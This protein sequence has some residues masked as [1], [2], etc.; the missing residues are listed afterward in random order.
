[1]SEGPL[2][3]KEIEGRRGY[4]RCGYR[5][6]RILDCLPGIALE[7]VVRVA[8]PIERAA[9]T[10]W[11]EA[12]RAYLRRAVLFPERLGANLDLSLHELDRIDMELNDKD[13]PL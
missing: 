4:S 8:R 10:A 9:G 12:R 11:R 1:M 13:S 6:A 3:T 2:G 7:G 5:I